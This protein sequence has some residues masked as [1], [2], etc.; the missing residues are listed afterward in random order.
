MIR[1]LLLPI[2]IFSTSIVIAQPANI[3]LSKN[4]WFPASKVSYSTGKYYGYS[5]PQIQQM[6]RNM[7]EVLEVLHQT[8]ILNPPRGYEAGIWATV[9]EDGCNVNGIMSG[10]SGVI[11]R[12]FHT[13]ESNPAFLRDVEGPSMKFFF[14]DIRR[15]LTRQ[16]LVPG[17]FYEEVKPVSE[18]RGYPVYPGGLLVLTKKKLPLFK[19]VSREENLKK[20]ISEGE[21]DLKEIR[22]SFSKGTHY[23]HYMANREENKK[24]ILAGLEYLAKSDPA[25]AASEKKKYLENLRKQDSAMLADKDKEIADRKKFLQTREAALQKLKDELMGLNEAEKASPAVGSNGYRL[26]VPNP[27]YFDKTLPSSSI[28]LIVIDL[29]ERV[30]WKNS[31]T[32]AYAPLFKTIIETMDLSKMTSLLH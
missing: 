27:D 2:L 4:Y 1:S 22:E 17:A 6:Y 23:E 26:V 7:A 3:D 20:M 10:Q 11:F 14:N 13:K 9:C 8:P 12:M 25:K 29:N 28:Q 24:A 32:M 16:P 19:Y 31:I 30:Q 18:L 21:K 15:L 5:Q